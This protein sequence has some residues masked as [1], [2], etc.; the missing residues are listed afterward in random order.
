M[1]RA[2]QPLVNYLID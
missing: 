1:H 2:T